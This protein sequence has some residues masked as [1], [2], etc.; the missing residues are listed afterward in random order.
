MSRW[1]LIPAALPWAALGALAAAGCGTGGADSSP[2]P[3]ADARPPQKPEFLEVA[4]RVEESF[5]PF[6]GLAQVE[7]LRF[8]LQ[9]TSAANLEGR[10]FRAKFANELLRIGEIDQARELMN[11]TIA[12]SEADPARSAEEWDFY[13]VRAL[14]HLRKAEIE[15][16]VQRHNRDCC[17][18]PLKEGGVHTISEPARL[19]RQDYLHYLDGA[20]PPSGE[21]ANDAESKRITAMWLLNIAC[22]AL[23]EFPEG[24]PPHYRMSSP[25]NEA[26]IDIGRFVDVGSRAGIDAF[27][28]AGG[29]IVD[30]FDGD[31]LLDVVSSCSAVRGPM[32]AFRNRGDGT[33]EDVASAWRLDDQL[34][35]L[36]MAGAD[37]DNDGDLDIL[38]PRGA[39]MHEEGRI[40]K[41]LLRNDGA[42]GF[43]D[44]TR[45]AGLAEPR[46]PSQAVVWA[47]F[48]LDGWLDFYAGNE[49][50]VETIVGGTSN[51]SQ[52][53]HNNGDGTFTDVARS[54]GVQ[55]NR[56][57]KGVAAGDYDN[58][59]DVDL[60]VS[61]ISPTGT[62]SNRLYRNDG[63]M[64]FTD[65]AP[66]L[67][68]TGP[69]GRSFATWFFDFEND[70]DLDLWVN[71]YDA[72][73]SDVA[74]SAA[75][76]PHGGEPP[77][78]YRNEGNG[79]FT[80]VAR[81]V[82]IDRAWLPM[83]SSFGDLDNDGWLDVYL[84]TGDPAYESLMPNIALRNDRGR[85]FQDVTRSSGL[86][87]LQKGH[88]VVFADVDDDGDQDIFHQLGGFYPGDAFR[89]A[90]FLNPGHGNHFLV[91]ELSGTKTNRQGIGARIAVHL[92]TPGARRT[93]HRAVGS[94]SSFGQVP[95]RQEIGLGNAT[96]IAS[97]EVDWPVSK[98]RTTVTGVPLDSFIRI[99]EGKSGFETLSLRPMQFVPKV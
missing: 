67:N 83:G 88:E 71:A 60:Y 98:L 48:D 62:S 26:Q 9:V 66:T 42:L 20:P 19:A 52:L 76:K 23:D 32:K 57:T 78:L 3:L 51:P 39:W 44:V 82:G 54:A 72:K 81:Q 97:I 43:T 7:E 77:C 95:R 1:P 58:D 73:I 14:A 2:I 63:E 40:R 79:T 46:A 36:H 25:D 70:G 27:D 41:S 31:G 38:V 99:T 85:R 50:R 65:V 84:G 61:N 21:D 87:H 56:F 34:G 16:C 94:V 53:F 37:Y 90:L 33:F 47:D 30:D 4:E 6:I 12:A 96:S 74:L 80:N 18:F 28:H 59:G 15:N 86:G 89:N 45:T 49:S 8:H 11:E 35:G 64:M 24:V 10:K 29:A 13:L 17:I 55:N 91:I 22:M 92:E 93:L 68:V 75:G 5:N 69:K